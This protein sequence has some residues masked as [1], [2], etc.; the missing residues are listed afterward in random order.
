MGY[1]DK[2]LFKKQ[3]QKKNLKSDKAIK[4]FRSKSKNIYISFPLCG[5]HGVS[6]RHVHY[7]LFFPLCKLK[8]SQNDFNNQSHIFHGLGTIA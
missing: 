3:G 5:L 2:Q 7:D 6:K 1:I 4:N 8:S